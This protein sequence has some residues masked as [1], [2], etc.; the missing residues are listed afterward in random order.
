MSEGWAVETLGIVAGLCTTGS[1]V[2]QVVKTWRGG[3]TGAISTRMYIIISVAFV[4][5]LC[6]GVV[7]GS[8]PMIAF[9]I[10]NLVLGGM[11]LAMKFRTVSRHRSNRAGAVAHLRSATRPGR[12]NDGGQVPGAER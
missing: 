11:I 12:S 7:I 5:W 2:P 6:Y 4:L 10:L 1:F 3:E 8:W 9:N